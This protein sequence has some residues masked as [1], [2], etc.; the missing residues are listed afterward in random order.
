MFLQDFKQPNSRSL[1]LDKE[2]IDQLCRFLKEEKQSNQGKGLYEAL[3]WLNKFITYFEHDYN[4]CIESNADLL[5]APD[6]ELTE[7][8]RQIKKEQKLFLNKMFAQQ[9][10][11]IIEIILIYSQ[12]RMMEKNHCTELV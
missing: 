8:D 10:P 3:W 5:N 9:F 2:I 11:D 4:E 1:E 6:E 7:E 12:K